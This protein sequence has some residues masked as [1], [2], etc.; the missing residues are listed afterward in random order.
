MFERIIR[1]NCVKDFEEQKWDIINYISHNFEYVDKNDYRE[2]WCFYFGKNLFYLVWDNGI[3]C[4]YASLN[5]NTIFS[6]VLNGKEQ[7][8]NVRGEFN[9]LYPQK[10]YDKE[11]VILEYE[12]L[13]ALLKEYYETIKSNKNPTLKYPKTKQVGYLAIADYKE[14]WVYSLSKRSIKTLN[15]L[16]SGKNLFVTELTPELY[17]DFIKDVFIEWCKY[18]QYDKKR[19]DF[20]LPARTFALHYMEGRYGNL[21]KVKTK[22]D[23]KDWKLGK[24]GWTTDGF[25]NDTHKS[26]S[27]I[28]LYI[29]IR[30]ENEDDF[31]GHLWFG[32]SEWYFPELL[33][34]WASLGKKYN[35]VVELLDYSEWRKVYIEQIPIK[36]SEWYYRKYHINYY[37]L[38]PIEKR[39]VKWNELKYSQIKKL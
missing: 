2:I 6:V 1:W 26:E 12:A 35:Y 10:V 17:F 30:Y 5:E 23:L 16:E 29:G 20:N 28:N 22:Q 33:K 13:L 18:N 7:F 14:H 19:F 27:K 8:L 21:I 9:P 39:K 31:V 36:V 3:N 11:N 32:G 34:I 25:N 37:E 4:W 15:H 24:E 38:T